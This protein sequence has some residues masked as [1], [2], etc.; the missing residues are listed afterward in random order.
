MFVAVGLLAVV[1]VTGGCSLP[2]ADAGGSTPSTFAVRVTMPSPL[3]TTTLPEEEADPAVEVLGV[4]DGDTIRVLGPAGEARV[5]LIGIDAPER[6]ACFFEEATDGMRLFSRVDTVRLV[7]DRSEVDRFDRLLRYVET[8]DGVD[9][10][11][12][13]VRAGFA[14]AISYEPDTAR[15]AIYAELE[16][17][18]RFEGRG[19]WADGVCT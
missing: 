19:L 3:E 15:D 11:A 6:D 9:V 12:E 14:R 8:T 5:R 1:A 13:L 2:A 4:I 16:A 17:E 10:G 18:A 7:R